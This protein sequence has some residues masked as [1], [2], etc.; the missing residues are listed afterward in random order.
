VLPDESDAAA[1]G[2]VEPDISIY[3]GP[4]RPVK[5]GD[6]DDTERNHAISIRASPAWLVNLTSHLG[7]VVRVGI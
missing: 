6:D 3:T 1:A 4:E 7:I 5:A 2:C